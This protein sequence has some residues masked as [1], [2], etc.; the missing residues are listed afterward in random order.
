MEKL[1]SDILFKI[2]GTMSYIL[3][4]HQSTVDY[5][6]PLRIL[7]YCV[8]IMEKIEKQEQINFRKMK[9]PTIYPIVLYTGTTKWKVTTKISEYQDNYL[10][11]RGVSL[12]KYKLLDI[13]NYTEE[14]LLKEKGTIEMAM[15]IERTKDS[16]ETIEIL[17]KMLQQKLG[18]E[19]KKFLK[20]VWKTTLQKKIGKEK[21]EEMLEKMNIGKGEKNKRS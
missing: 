14:E 5:R 2:K 15:L 13:N 10:E 17:N 18:K 21:T 3:I 9:F 11:I 19:E 7:K 4:E 6:M 16:E 20:E 8:A 1:Q 12:A